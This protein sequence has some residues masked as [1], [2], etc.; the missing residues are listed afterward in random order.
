MRRGLV[1]LLESAFSSGQVEITAAGN[2]VASAAFLYGLA[3]EDLRP[4]DLAAVDP[5][6]PLLLCARARRAP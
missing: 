1:D 3:V 2:L 4:D 6:F 5:M